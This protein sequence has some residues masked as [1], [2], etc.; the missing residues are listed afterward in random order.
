[1]NPQVRESTLSGLSPSTTQDPGGTIPVPATGATA[2]G[3]GSPG[4]AAIRLTR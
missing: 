3:T 4:I 2:A 1:M